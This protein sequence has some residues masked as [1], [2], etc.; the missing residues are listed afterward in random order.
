MHED[1]TF[2]CWC[3]W[4]TR[5][6]RVKSINKEVKYQR[7]AG[8]INGASK[9]KWENQLRVCLRSVFL[10]FGACIDSLGLKNGKKKCLE[11]VILEFYGFWFCVNDIFVWISFLKKA[12]KALYCFRGWKG[13]DGLVCKGVI[14]Q[15]FMV[16]SRMKRFSPDKKNK[17]TLCSKVVFSWLQLLGKVFLGKFFKG[18]T[19]CF[20]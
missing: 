1:L 16:H 2:H 11:K 3:D 4:I 20:S 15:D 19:L 5:V 13:G 10:A 7:K 18:I 17:A 9:L 6:S 12:K 14:T 8:W